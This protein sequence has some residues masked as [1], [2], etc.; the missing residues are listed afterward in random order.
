MSD[1]DFDEGSARLAEHSFRIL[2]EGLRRVE[3]GN[4][5]K[6]EPVPRPAIGRIR[7]AV[8]RPT[9]DFREPYGPPPPDEPGEFSVIF[10]SGKKYTFA[11][12]EGQ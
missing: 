2:M 3:A 1:R 4:P 12:D 7:K 9:I 6:R 8:G 10:P 11:S 5:N